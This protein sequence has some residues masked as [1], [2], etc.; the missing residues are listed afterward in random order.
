VR[1]N[2]WSVPRPD[3]PMDEHEIALRTALGVGVHEKLKR[4]DV[5]AWVRDHL[6]QPA[7]EDHVASVVEDLMRFTTD[8]STE[9]M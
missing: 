9:E 8:L 2:K 7:D 6:R 4:S 5:D 3:F 1:K